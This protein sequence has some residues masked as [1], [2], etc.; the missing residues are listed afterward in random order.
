MLAGD[1]YGSLVAI[2]IPR[3]SEVIYTASESL[4][5]SQSSAEIHITSCTALPIG[6]FRW[7]YT[8]TASKFALG[9]TH[10]LTAM[11]YTCSKIHITS[12]EIYHA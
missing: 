4:C 3:P 2:V 9:K 1:L 6:D 11:F 12:E 5:N 8:N 10:L 7:G